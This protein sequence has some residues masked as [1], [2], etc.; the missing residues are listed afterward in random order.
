MLPAGVD[1]PH[2]HP[3]EAIAP[4]DRRSLHGAAQDAQ[5]LAEGRAE[6]RPGRDHRR[7]RRARA[8]RERLLDVAI[9]VGIVN[10]MVVLDRSPTLDLVFR[11]LAHPARRAI[12]RQLSRGERNLSALASPLKMTFPAATK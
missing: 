2:G 6:S 7:R 12:I 3:E 11:A 4:G 1:I 10:H 8:A 5:L 9:P